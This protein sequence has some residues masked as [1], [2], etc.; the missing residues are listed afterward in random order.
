MFF[1]FHTGDVTIDDDRV[2]VIGPDRF[3][4]MVVEAGLTSWLLRKVS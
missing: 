1:V 2:T 4:E 3:A